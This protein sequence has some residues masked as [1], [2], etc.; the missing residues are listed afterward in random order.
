MNT[1][2]LTSWLLILG[3]I[4]MFLIWFILDPMVI[5]DVPEGLSPSEEAIAG[6]QLD[7]DQ[8]AL[9]NVMNMIGGFAFM[10]IFAGLAMLSR[11]LQGGGAAFGT[12]AGILFPAVIAIAVAG[13]GLSVEAT[14]YL[15]DGNKDIAATLEITS[16]GLFGAMPMILGLGLILLGL[17][18]ARENGSLPALLGWVLFIFGIGM[19]SGM[20]LDFSGDNPIGMVVWM[21]WMIVTVVTGVISLRTSD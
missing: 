13:F 9:S 5:G 6:L 10:G 8:Q 2:S 18:I 4:G 12:L 3:P 1:R 15:A 16:N 7:L 19:M 11:T 14:N 21:G 17:G 20:F